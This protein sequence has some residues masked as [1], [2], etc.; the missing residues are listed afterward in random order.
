MNWDR[1]ESE[2]PQLL[3]SAK[4]EWPIFSDN[5]LIEIGG[6][7]TRLVMALQEGYGWSKG[8]AVTEAEGWRQSLLAHVRQ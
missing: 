3:R 1:I 7:R 6:D 2:W 4:A 5:D 8:R